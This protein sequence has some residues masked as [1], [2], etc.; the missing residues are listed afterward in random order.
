MSVN[1][2]HSRK[3]SM[4]K[5]KLKNLHKLVLF[6]FITFTCGMV[7]AQSQDPI[8]PHL[9]INDVPKDPLPPFY[10]NTY[11][12]LDHNWDGRITLGDIQAIPSD[13]PFYRKIQHI[14]LIRFKKGDPAP[15][16]RKINPIW[17]K[18]DFHKKI[19]NSS[20]NSR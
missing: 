7:H 15:P 3:V 12:P 4:K 18:T 14:I 5:N 16:G 10:I 20:L 13:Y 8:L 6:A 17:N 11:H 1:Y 9:R 2:T 19:R